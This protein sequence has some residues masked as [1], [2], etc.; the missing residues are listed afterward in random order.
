MGES[1][2]RKLIDPN[3]GAIPKIPKANK[4]VTQLLEFQLE[5]RRL[6][7]IEIH[8][9]E[10]WHTAALCCVGSQ[11]LL[12]EQHNTGGSKG[13]GAIQ[14]CSYAEIYARLSDH[15]L[16]VVKDLVARYPDQLLFLYQETNFPVMAFSYSLEELK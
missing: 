1:K 13:L 2:R 10:L 14:N 11:A 5:I 7:L 3:Y 12:L 6:L 8:S 9:R 4:D 16:S 15:D